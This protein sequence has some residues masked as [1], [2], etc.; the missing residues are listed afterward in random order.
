MTLGLLDAM[1]E[2]ELSPGEDIVI[3][4]IDGEQAAID[5][6]ARGEVNCVIECN[7]N[8]GPE[9]MQLTRRLAAGGAIPRLIHVKEQVF[10]EGDDLRN[11]KPRGY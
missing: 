7:P 9:I 5:A 10:Y 1:K 6:L 11:L 2:R 3:I 4:T 8:Q